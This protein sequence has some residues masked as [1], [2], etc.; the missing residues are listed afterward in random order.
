MKIEGPNFGNYDSRHLNIVRREV[1]QSIKPNLFRDLDEGVAQALLFTDVVNLSSE[2]KALLKKLK[3]QMAGQKEAVA[4][5]ES[6]VQELIYTLRQLRALVNADEQHQNEG[7]QAPVDGRATAKDTSYTLPHHPMQL[8]SV[9]RG[10]GGARRPGGAVRD[11]IERMIGYAPS[12]PARAALVDELVVLGEK[13]CDTVA[14]FGVKVI[15]LEPTRAVTDVRLAG[16]MIVAPHEKTFDGRP[17]A[18]VRG[19]YDQSRRIMVIGQEKLGQAG[20]S[21]A[22][23]EFA[24][25]FD[26]TFTVRHSRRQPL[27]VQLWNLFAEQRRGLVTE[28][29]GTNPSEYWAESVESFFKPNGRAL[30]MDRDPQMHQYLEA[31]FAS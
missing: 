11:I 7:E 23:H 19:L 25:A 29:A 5:D 10:G 22:R 31:L 17:W 20:H 28:Y 13:M 8:G 26:H 1:P 2:A 15:I 6:S 27:S 18:G 3:K 4:H 9:V 14:R 12:D 16:M 24:H 21:T 30:L